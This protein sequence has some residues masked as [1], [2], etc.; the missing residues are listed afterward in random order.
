MPSALIFAGFAP[1]TIRESR[2]RLA[3][4]SRGEISTSGCG[5]R[6][7]VI[8]ISTVE[9]ARTIRSFMQ[10]RAH[11]LAVIAVFNGGLSRPL[12]RELCNSHIY[13]S[14]NYGAVQIMS[15]SRAC[16]LLLF[17]YAKRVI[18]T[19][20]AHARLISSEL[21]FRLYCSTRAAPETRLSFPPVVIASLNEQ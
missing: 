16:V 17:E 8:L 4:I 20:A 11:A 13:K 1:S 21:R 5:R 19:S 10:M 6:S 2:I 14:S 15:V 7:I 9:Y 12:R 18:T 3:S